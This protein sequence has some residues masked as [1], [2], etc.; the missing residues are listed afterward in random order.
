MPSVLWAGPES[1]AKS[2]R[3][4]EHPVQGGRRREPAH[5]RMG[6]ADD[7]LSYAVYIG[8]PTPTFDSFGLDLEIKRESIWHGPV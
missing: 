1:F 4:G 5:L 6:F 2:V 7:K 3:R 8:L